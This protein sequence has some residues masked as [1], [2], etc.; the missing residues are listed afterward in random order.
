MIKNISKELIIYSDGGARGN[1]GP[2]ALGV[3]IF[4]P[5]GKLLSKHGHYLGIK[6]NNFAEYSALIFALKEA[7]RLKAKSVKCYLDSELV[8]RQLLGHYRVKNQAYKPNSV[9]TIS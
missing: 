5:A 1:P 3:A 8:V 4:N 2:A 6:T 9:R 7:H